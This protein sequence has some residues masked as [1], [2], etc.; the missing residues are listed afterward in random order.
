MRSQDAK[1]GMSRSGLSV[2][3]VGALQVG[4]CDVIIEI[5]DILGIVN[6]FAERITYYRPAL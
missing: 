1:H 4:Y 5:N 3:F 2:L 6:H